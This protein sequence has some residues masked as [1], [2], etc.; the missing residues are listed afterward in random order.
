MDG[1][2]ER[3]AVTTTHVWDLELSVWDVRGRGG[4]GGGAAAAGPR[5]GQCAYSSMH[6]KNNAYSIMNACWRGRVAY[7]SR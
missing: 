5:G 4:L 2:D 7:V 3:T 6:I 1:R